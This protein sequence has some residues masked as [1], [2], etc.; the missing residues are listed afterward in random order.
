MGDRLLDRANAKGL[1][2]L[3]SI[4]SLSRTPC[5]VCVRSKLDA[6]ANSPAD[7]TEAADVVVPGNANFQLDLIKTVP[8]L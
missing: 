8:P 5:F 1:K 7:Y 2:I 6:R 3:N 4:D